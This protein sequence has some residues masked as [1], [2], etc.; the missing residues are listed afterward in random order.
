MADKILESIEEGKNKL[1]CTLL[2]DA[3]NTLGRGF[4]AKKIE[5]ITSHIPTIMTQR[6][7]PSVHE[8]VAIKGVE[9]KTA[10]TFVDN[11]PKFFEFLDQS[12]LTHV[13]NVVITGDTKENT[14]DKLKDVVVVFTGVR[15]KEVEGFVTSHGGKVSSSVTKKT[16]VLV[17]KSL[18]GDKESS[19]Y[20]QAKEL[21]IKVLTLEAF[22]KEINF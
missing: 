4:G 13:C 7:I 5:L 1:S 9:Q 17:V 18:E 15:S 19:K 3:S 6:Y 10:Q 2:M 14:D 11:L 22:K 12:K 8:L 16:T 21:G 20:K